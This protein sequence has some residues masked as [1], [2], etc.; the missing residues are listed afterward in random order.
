[1]SGSLATGHWPLP[2]GQAGSN[3]FRLLLRRLLYNAAASSVDDN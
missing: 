2:D 3:S 1:M